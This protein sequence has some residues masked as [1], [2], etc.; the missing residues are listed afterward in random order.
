MSHSLRNAFLGA[1]AFLLSTPATRAM[2]TTPAPEKPA[3]DEAALSVEQSAPFIIITQ[4]KGPNAPLITTF[5][6][7]GLDDA[8]VTRLPEID[9]LAID[10]PNENKSVV[11]HWMSGTP[12]AEK[13][14]SFDSNRTLVQTPYVSRSCVFDGDGM[15]TSCREATP[16]SLRGQI[17]ETMAVVRTTCDQVVAELVA[18]N[19]INHTTLSPVRDA[20]AEL[21]RVQASYSAII[22]P[23]QR[24]VLVLPAQSP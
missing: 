15:P 23:T 22:A 7:I 19:A 14:D 8:K 12:V 21:L 2:I 24:S 6:G 4:D 1:A 11:Y 10:D 13:A 16:T 20:A 3:E 17:T 9:V 5:C 18:Q